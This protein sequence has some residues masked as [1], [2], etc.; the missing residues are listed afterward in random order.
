MA[1]PKVRAEPKIS[2]LMRLMA[3]SLPMDMVMI[4]S[5]GYWD[6]TSSVALS[7]VR[8]SFAELGMQAS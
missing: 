5:S 6:F 7:R 4:G 2:P 8:T 3:P 1:E